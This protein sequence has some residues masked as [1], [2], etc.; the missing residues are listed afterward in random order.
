M[1][2]V[3]IV[4][5][6]LVEKLPLL[7]ISGIANLLSAIITAKYFEMTSGDVAITI[8]T[9]SVEMYQSRLDELKEERGNYKEIQ[10]ALDYE[11]CLLGQKVDNMRELNYMDQKAI[12]N[13]KYFT[14]VEQQAKDVKDL[15][16]LWTDC[17]FVG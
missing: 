1:A 4:L 14:W 3:H 16:Q 2:L 7:G 12:H 17:G 10:A 15:N 6:E 8:A 5:K 9:D 13:L 11:S